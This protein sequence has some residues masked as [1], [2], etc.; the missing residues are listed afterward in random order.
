MKREKQK[1]AKVVSILLNEWLNDK[2]EERT[3]CDDGREKSR[4]QFGKE[5]MVWQWSNE[6]FMYRDPRMKEKWAWLICSPASP[7]VID[8][9]Q[10]NKQMYWGK[11][12]L[13]TQK[14]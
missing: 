11:W 13:S 1:N 12:V 5:K 10:E 3:E 6:A 7:C 2:V 8:Q 14:M 9:T 4:K